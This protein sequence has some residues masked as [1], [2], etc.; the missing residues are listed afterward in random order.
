MQ[1]E[2]TV[3]KEDCKSGKRNLYKG[4]KQWEESSLLE[5]LTRNKTAASK[6]SGLK[7]LLSSAFILKVESVADTVDST[8][9]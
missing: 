2:R 3:G 8:Y 6:V 4:D 9:F 5:R 1:A 7:S